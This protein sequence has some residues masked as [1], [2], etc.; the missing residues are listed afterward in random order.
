MHYEFDRLE[1]G[2]HGT[3]GRKTKL[4]PDLEAEIVGNVRKGLSNKVACRM[5]GIGETT[6]YRWSDATLH[7]VNMSFRPRRTR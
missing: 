3:V 1:R 6:F 2:T 4:T 7:R 5:A